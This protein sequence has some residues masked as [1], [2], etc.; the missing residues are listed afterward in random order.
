MLIFLCTWRMLRA[1]ACVQSVRESELDEALAL[2]ARGRIWSSA[3]QV[4]VRTHP[5]VCTRLSTSYAGV[6]TVPWVLGGV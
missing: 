3:V 5:D 4:C 1:L 6:Q 2:A